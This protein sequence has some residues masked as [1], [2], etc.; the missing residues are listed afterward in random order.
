[1]WFGKDQGPGH[2][3]SDEI[4]LSAATSAGWKKIARSYSYSRSDDYPETRI[5]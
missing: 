1:M 4:S 2:S 3:R 5:L